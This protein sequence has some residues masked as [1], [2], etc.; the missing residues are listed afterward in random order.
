VQQSKEGQTI[1]EKFEDTKGVQQS[2]E[3]Q[4]IQEKFE[5]TKGVQQSKEGQT[6]KNLKRH[7]MIHLILT[8]KLKLDKYQP[9]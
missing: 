4:T 1:Q 9:H 2:K 5:D 8:R 3:G 6:R 7:T